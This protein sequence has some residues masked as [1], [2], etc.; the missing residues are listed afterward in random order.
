M[1]RSSLQLAAMDIIITTIIITT[2]ITTIAARAIA[3]QESPVNV[4]GLSIFFREQRRGP[5]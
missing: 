1:L 2:T 3:V 4:T 5:R